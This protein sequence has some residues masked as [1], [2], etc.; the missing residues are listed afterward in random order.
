MGHLFDKPIV[1]KDEQPEEPQVAQ[2][3]RGTQEWA[4]AKLAEIYSRI[5]TAGSNF[6]S[7]GFR[8]KLRNEVREMVWDQ[9]GVLTIE[10]YVVNK[11][12]EHE[13]GS[14]R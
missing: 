12:R 4:R 10:E 1:P 13:L 8:E 2:P 11:I 7:I 5:D 6:V 14:I 9:V 3:K